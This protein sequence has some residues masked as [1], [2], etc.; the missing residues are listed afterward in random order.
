VTHRRLK[1]GAFRYL[2]EH[3]KPPTSSPT[4]DQILNWLSYSNPSVQGRNFSGLCELGLGATSH[5]IPPRATELGGKSGGKELR[6]KRF[7]G[8]AIVVAILLA[9]P[10]QGHA[11]QQSFTSRSEIAGFRVAA[12][13]QN[14]ILM[15]DAQRAEILPYA[16]HAWTLGNVIGVFGE[17]ALEGHSLQQVLVAEIAN[18]SQECEGR[19]LSESQPPQ[20]IG[21]ATMVRFAVS[22]DT[23]DGT[24]IV[25]G[26]LVHGPATGRFVEHAG[27]ADFKAEIRRAD[28][29]VAATME[30]IYLHD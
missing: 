7:V 13:L 18:I 21:D 30:G 8:G 20:R 19:I 28:D 11:R 27:R 17:Y 25:N 4:A 9:L 29:L 5:L 10:S 14:A 23:A 1:R 26:T 2:A 6:L 22:C 15:T 12:G 24:I 3:K 16:H